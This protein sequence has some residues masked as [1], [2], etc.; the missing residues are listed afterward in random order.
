MDSQSV[1]DFKEKITSIFQQQGFSTPQSIEKL[2]KLHQKYMLYEKILV[3]PELCRAMYQKQ[4]FYEAFSE[5][6][7]KCPHS[8]KCNVHEKDCEQCLM[9]FKNGYL[10]KLEDEPHIVSAMTCPETRIEYAYAKPASASNLL[11]HY[12]KCK[13]ANHPN[14]FIKLLNTPGYHS[15][16]ADLCDNVISDNFHTNFIHLGRIVLIPNSEC[17]CISFAFQHFK[18]KSKL[19]RGRKFF[20]I[21]SNSK[22]GDISDKSFY[23]ELIWKEEMEQLSE[24]MNERIDNHHIVIVADPEFKI[25]QEDINNVPWKPQNVCNL[26]LFCFRTIL[27]IREESKQKILSFLPKQLLAEISNLYLK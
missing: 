26:K 16:F 24:M 11:A 12:N 15:N 6:G 27:R 4:M 10:L 20:T 7:F 25:S 3:S 21:S 14:V 17:D 5:F 8:I 22:F 9:S 18:Q 2:R 13:R 1:L 19:G 23:F